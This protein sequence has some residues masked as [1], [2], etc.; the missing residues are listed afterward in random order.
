MLLCSPVAL[1]FLVMNWSLAKNAFFTQLAGLAVWAL[2]FFALPSEMR[3]KVLAN[4]ASFS[5]AFAPSEKAVASEPSPASLAA[6]AALA[7]LSASEA[8]LRA[9]KASLDPADTKG[10][11]ELTA[12]ILAYNRQLAAVLAQQKSAQSSAFVQ[13]FAPE[14]VAMRDGV[15]KPFGAHSLSE[16]K[17]IAVYFSASW[18]PPC[19]AFT[20]ELVQFYNQQKQA[21]A[22]FEVILVS[23]DK[24]AAAMERY[25]KDHGMAWPAVAFEK[26]RSSSLAKYAGNGIPC[27]VLLDEHGKVLSHSY[28]GSRY[29]GPKKVLNDIAQR[30][31]TASGTQIASTSATR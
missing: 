10:A 22:P 14:L 4:P 1:V 27:L 8:K 29:V 13:A 15:L 19:R 25:M 28:E 17:L 6:A 2:A 24:D 11:E 20:P 12:E 21:G 23:S 9:R 3:S 16:A 5:S 30:L 18:C 7:D 26:R 31:R